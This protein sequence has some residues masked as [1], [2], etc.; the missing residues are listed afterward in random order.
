LD[1]SLSEFKIFELDSGELG[2]EVAAHLDTALGEISS[3]K[4]ND[5]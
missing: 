3:S 2:R 4:F 1:V 5:G